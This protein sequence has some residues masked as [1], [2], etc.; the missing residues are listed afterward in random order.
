MP[1]YS[2]FLEVEFHADASNAENCIC[3]ACHN[4]GK[5]TKLRLPRTL[6][7]GGHKLSTRYSGY[8][9]CASCAEKLFCV[10]QDTQKHFVKE[11]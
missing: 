11:Y 8:W 7:Y 10:L 6:Y 3:D 4:T 9:L 1:G 2:D 5:V